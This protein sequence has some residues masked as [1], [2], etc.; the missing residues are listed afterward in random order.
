M[1]DESSVIKAMNYIVKQGVDGVGPL[2]SA[3]KLANEYILDTSYA[4]N[5][6][7]VS[8]LINWEVSKNFT[9]GFLSGLG[10]LITLPVTVPAGLGASWIIQARMSGAIASI[11]GHKTTDDRVR[12][13]ILLSLLGDVGKEVLK[14]VA[15]EAGVKY[16]KSF[17]IQHLS[18]NILKEINKAV[19]F[20]LVT[21]A[22]QN[23][24]VNLSKAVPFVGGIIC[25]TIDASAC[26]T[27]GHAAN[28]IFKKNK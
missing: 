14:S 27:V 8:S 26:W 3:E 28:K 16:T 6:N 15:V 12:T 7:R 25:G 21:K 18:G 17:I 2:C 23:G 5:E 11:H 19:G 1:S 4:D 24:V 9:S 10:G 22:G 13:L 20:R